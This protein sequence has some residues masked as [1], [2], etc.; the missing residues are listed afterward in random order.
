MIRRHL[1][2]KII[3][4]V[5]AFTL[6]ISYLPAQGAKAYN[7]SSRGESVKSL[8]E[9][10][11]MELDRADAELKR[12]PIREGVD[13]SSQEY[14]SIIV[15]F[16]SLP[17]ITQESLNGGISTF[18]MSNSVENEH[19]A[20]ESFINAKGKER[21]ETYTIKHSYYNTFNGVSMSIKGV[22]IEGLLDSGVVKAIWKD[23]VVKADPIENEIKTYSS[24]TENPNSRMVSSTPLIGVDKLREEG[25]TGEGVKVGVLDTGI[26]Y[27][28]PDLKGNFKGGYDFVD[29]DNDPMETTYEDWLSSGAPEIEGG[30]SFYTSHGTHVSGTIAATGENSESEFAVTGLAPDVDLY[31]YRVLGPYGSGATSGIIAA[32]EQSVKDEMDVINLSLGATSTNPLSPT[33]IACNNASLAGVVTVVANGNAGPGLSTL[34]APGTSALAISV[35]A[36]S[37]YINVETFDINLSNGKTID[38]RLFARKFE[39]LDPFVNG[40]Y[41]IV[42]VGYGFESDFIDLDVKNKIVLIDRGELS[43]TEKLANAANAGAAGAI[44]VNNIPGEELNL[45]LGEAEKRVPAI[46]INMENGEKIKGFIEEANNSG[47]PLKTTL[48]VTGKATTEGDILADFSSRGPASDGMIKPDVVAPGDA[49]FSTY[50]E[51]INSPEEGIDYNNAYSRISGTS[52]ASPHV[53][54]VAALMIQNDKTLTPSEL[55]VSLM[56][57]SVNLKEEYPI[58]AVGAGRVDAYKAVHNDVS[59][60]VLDKSESLDGNNNL[61][62]IDYLTGSLSFDRV[63]TNDEDREKSLA[64]SLNNKGDVNKNFNISVEYLGEKALAEDAKANGVV[65]DV[66]EKLTVNAKEDVNINA[67]IKIPSTAAQGRYEGYIIFTNEEDSNEVYRTPFSVTYTEPGIKTLDFSRPAI[68]NDLEMMHFIKDLGIS[69]Y[70]EPSS[71]ID[72][73]EVFVND[74]ETGERIGLA[75][76]IDLSYLPAGYGDAFY[77]LNSRASYFPMDG[78]DITFT[79]SSLTDGKYTLDVVAYA[80]D[81]QEPLVYNYNILVDNEDVQITMEEKA[82]VYEISDDMYTT[83]E[84]FGEMHEAFWVHGNVD[85]NSIEALQEMGHDVTK[86]DII[87]NGFM[88]G[89]PRWGIPVDENGNFKMGIEK[90]DLENGVIEISPM[91]TDIAT[92]QN[93]FMPPRYFFV[94]EGMPYSS[95]TLDKKDMSKGENI[96]ST[97]SVKNLDGGSNFNYVLTYLKDF[98]IMDIKLNKDLQKIV[99]E[100]GYKY[101]ID[102]KIQGA[103]V[104]YIELNLNITDKDGNNV[105]ISGDLGL[106]DIEFKLV[107][108]SNCEFYREYIECRYLTVKDKDGNITN[109]SNKATYEGVNIKQSTSSVRAQ[110]VGEGFLLANERGKYNS[111]LDKYIWVEDTEGNKYELIYSS[112]NDEYIAQDL[113]TSKE[114]YKVVTDLPGHFRKEAKFIPSR[115]V[116]GETLGKV[117]YLLGS[118][119]YNYALAGDVNKDDVIDIHDALEVEKYYGQKVDYNEVPVDFNFDGIVDCDD[120]DFIIFNFLRGN[121][122]NSSK[123][124]PEASYNGRTLEDIIKSTGYY[125]EIRLEEISINETY[126]SL[127]VNDVENNTAQLVITANP[128]EAPLELVWESKCEDIATVDGN[129]LVTAVNPGETDIKV[130]L[131]NGSATLYCA[132]TVTKDGVIPQIED[133]IVEKD[134]FDIYVGEEAELNFSLNTEDIVVKSIKYLSTADSIATVVDGKVVGKAEG[135]AIITAAINDG[136]GYATWEI[137]VKEKEE[138]E[139]VKKVTNLRVTEKHSNSVKLEWE[140]PKTGTEVAEYIIYKDGKEIDRV[141][142]NDRLEY[143][144][145]DLKANTIYGFKVV[146]EGTRGMKSKP[147]SV[148]VR[149]E[150]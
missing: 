57:S 16:N 101:T 79:R 97:I 48:K 58:N 27:N 106:L 60:S 43:F 70:I 85:D 105:D 115:M 47:N 146:S 122:Q 39:S 139:D 5:L 30:S 26:D 130:S 102:K 121:E 19:K 75:G 13:T 98:E 35:G 12:N 118:E 63:Y 17:L 123:K 73:I 111:N 23:D 53:A 1:G 20:F 132:I 95:I 103:M 7:N 46:A 6:F 51:Y 69:A 4:G 134:K 67:T 135:K 45:Y 147:V 141:K 120:L 3:G 125:D 25:L 83:E 82:G 142:A 124:T 137:T 38:G 9:K 15:E 80:N 148:N 116:N 68:S 107:D 131:A 99:N 49:I 40:E 143:E 52:M 28:H 29:N 8:A 55:K 113:P 24:N 37:T 33:S 62:E 126:L 129:G 108:D 78:D 42:N 22:D 2:K 109:M 100:K 56:N 89:M 31:A 96:V 14:Q 77:M 149:T 144:V 92:S 114:E 74:Y 90:S 127:D 18:D 117:Y 86:K 72:H 34:G 36:S 145:T 112:A 59:I 65:L 66:P 41:E 44:V 128:A 94:K 64:L 10:Y 88:N 119:F 76:Y 50:P 133:V 61:I 104:R 91:P 138:V 54:G 136:A 81:L 71:P 87:I 110:Q 21:K 140:A 93:L 11:K 150:K 32:I 84:Y